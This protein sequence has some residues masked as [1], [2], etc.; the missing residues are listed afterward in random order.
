M[1]RHPAARAHRG[2]DKDELAPNDGGGNGVPTYLPSQALAD[3]ASLPERRARLEPWVR[4]ANQARNV[5][6]VCEGTRLCTVCNRVIGEGELDFLVVLAGA[7]ALRVDRECLDLWHEAVTN[8]RHR[9]STDLGCERPGADGDH[10]QD[11]DK[12]LQEELAAAIPLTPSETLAAFSPDLRSIVG[13][14]ARL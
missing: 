8:A 12:K 1:N 14:C 10:G 2:R 5:G 3:R 11:D 6:G 4:F 7:V 9:A 13:T